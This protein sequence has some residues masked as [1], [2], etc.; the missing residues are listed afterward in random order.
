M[1]NILTAIQKAKEHPDIEG[2]YIEAQDLF[3]VTPAMAREIRET[4]K[5]F[6]TSGKFIIAY[7]DNYT[8]SCYYICSV[9][10]RLILN[11]QGQVNW[12][13]MASQPIFYKDLLEKLGVRMQIFKVGSYKSAVEPFN[14]T[15]MSEAN[16]E[17]A[18]AAI[19]T[20]KANITLSE[21][22]LKLAQNTLYVKGTGLN[23]VKLDREQGVVQ[24]ET[25]SLQSLTY[26]Q[27]SLGVKGFF[28]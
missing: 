6:K 13:G 11:P 23:V 7:G 18:L 22:Q 19:E 5:D 21:A 3:G 10:D 25:K 27:N 15:R 14:S 28:R 20:A 17:Q 2:I 16:R 9:A 8:Q 12:C 26:R 24:M 4:L 1:K